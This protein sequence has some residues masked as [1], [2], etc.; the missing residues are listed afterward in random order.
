M[1]IKKKFIIACILLLL[2]IIL[3]LFLSYQHFSTSAGKFCTFGDSFSCD[4]VNKSPY[5]NLDGISYLL[6]IDFGLNLPLV[7]ISSIN[8][9][10]NLITSVAFLGFLLISLI[11]LMLIF[12]NEKKDFLFV[13][14]NRIFLWARFMLIFG[15]LF[16]IYLFLIQH[17]IL[18]TYCILCI[19]LDIILIILLFTI[20]RLE[21]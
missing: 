20:W 10:L 15:V 8:W 14:H 11:F 5:S 13:K 16:G 17:F 6:T 4:I 7:D 19:A 2:G 3:S 1:V 12:Y 18:K 9:F 21:K